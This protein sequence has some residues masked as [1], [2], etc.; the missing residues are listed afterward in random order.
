ME[1]TVARKQLKLIETAT[2]APLAHRSP[3][4][5]G[6]LGIAKSEAGLLALIAIE[7]EAAHA[8]RSFKKE[9][10]AALNVTERYV[11][12]LLHGKA[13]ATPSQLHIAAQACS[14]DLFERWLRI[15]FL[16]QGGSDAIPDSAKL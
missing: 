12:D 16:S 5:D 7:F 8:G 4:G 13:N 15:H 9:V 14:S 11:G 1:S 2:S 3:I 10:A 6:V